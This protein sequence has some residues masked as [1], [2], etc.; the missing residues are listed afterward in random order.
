MK[1]KFIH[2]L[3]LSLAFVFIF[4]ASALVANAQGDVPITGSIGN[5]RLQKGRTV[6]ALVVMD[7]PGGLHINSNRPLSKYAVPTRVKATG[8]GLKLGVVS[9][10]RAR[11]Q[12]FS[13]SE[14][15]IAVFDGRTT[16]RVPVTVPANFSGDVA[17]IRIV[18]TYQSCTDEVCYR[19]RSGEIT[20]SAAVR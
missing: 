18:V 4:G 2:Q 5:G 1:H 6:T 14:D 10:P 13:F 12:K 9:Y 15:Q 3:V 8:T 19:P 20:L 11:V 16:F 7:I 17:K